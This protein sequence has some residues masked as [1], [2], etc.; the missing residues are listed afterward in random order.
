MSRHPSTIAQGNEAGAE[1]SDGHQTA[2]QTRASS[3]SSSAKDMTVM[4]PFPLEAKPAPLRLV[5]QCR[6]T[7]YR[8]QTLYSKG[9]S[10]GAQQLCEI[11]TT[12]LRSSD[13]SSAVN[14]KARCVLEIFS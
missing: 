14:S 4:C 2:H 5:L 9:I 10:H 13:N 1:R 11:N 6:A 12:Q 3:S 7:T 8:S